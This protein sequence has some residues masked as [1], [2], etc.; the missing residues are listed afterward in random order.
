LIDEFLQPFSCVAGSRKPKIVIVG[1]ALGAS[2]DR[3]KKPFVGESGKEL[4]KMM[5]D[6]WPDVNSKLAAWVRKCMAGESLWAKERE[7]WLEQAGVMLTNSF[8]FRP[9]DNKIDELCSDRKSVG[10]D[11]ALPPLRTGKYI[12]QEYFPHTDRLRQE[13][14]LTK[15]NLVICVGNVACWS[16]LRATNI[17]SIRGNI[18]HGMLLPV[19]V[20][21]TFHPA[22]VLREWSQR[23][24]VVT[25]FRKAWRERDFPDIRRPERRIIVYPT[26]A[27]VAT[28]AAKNR[29]APIISCDI[30]T[31]NGQIT[32]IGFST[33][34]RE[35]LVFTF[36]YPKGHPKQYQSVYET[37]E[38]ELLAWNT[39]EEILD[40]PGEKLF[41]NGLFDIQFLMRQGMRPKNCLQ[42]TMLRHHSIFPELK[43]GLGFLGSIYTNESS[44]KLMRKHKEELKRDE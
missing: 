25:D 2:E 18:T 6:A 9:T 7:P 10:K 1:E 5:N 20:L 27:E 21:P 35:A 26:W 3:L 22:S 19:K 39:V 44:W 28:W 41:Q 31:A 37:M 17:G 34:P 29:D 42:D 8:N 4:F 36:V 30:E 16:I 33:T 13:L 43:K 40:W 11:Y 32:D 12:R 24:I 38:D 14:E 15:P 23:T